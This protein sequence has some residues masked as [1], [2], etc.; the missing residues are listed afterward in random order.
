MCAFRCVYV[1]VFA[2]QPV[3][4]GV[5]LHA[6]QFQVSMIFGVWHTEGGNSSTFG[7]RQRSVLLVCDS[8]SGLQLKGTP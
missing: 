6:P 1:I 8:P 2:R 4:G 5:Q 7:R 3:P